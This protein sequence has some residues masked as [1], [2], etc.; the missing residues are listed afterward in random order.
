MSIIAAIDYSINSPAICVYNTSQEF[1]FENCYFYLN[2]EK[3]SKKEQKQRNNLNLQ[4]INWSIRPSYNSNIE[5]Y[6]IVADWAMSIIVTHNVEVIAL[7]DYSLH[8]KGKIFNIAEATGILKYYLFTQ[9]I[10]VYTFPPSQNKKI[11]SGK[12]NANKALMID[13]FNQIHGINIAEQLGHK[14]DFTGS[15]VSDIVDS[16]SLINTFLKERTML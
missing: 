12:G 7:E 1:C 15:P 14:K 10:Q 2:Q 3:I 4:N 6:S 8:A 11:F 16:Y 13:T 5:R 9:G